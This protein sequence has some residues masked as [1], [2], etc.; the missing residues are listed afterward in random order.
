MVITDPSQSS[1]RYISGFLTLV[2]HVSK[3]TPVKIILRKFSSYTVRLSIPSLLD[4]LF[5]FI[6]DNFAELLAKLSFIK[7]FSIVCYLYANL[8]V[9]FVMSLKLFLTV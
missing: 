9:T 5:F 4:F 3:H 6:N 7:Q 1:Y 2:I 8:S